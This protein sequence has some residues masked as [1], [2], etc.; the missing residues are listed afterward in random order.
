MH[1]V[2]DQRTLRWWRV[3]STLAAGNLLLW[4]AVAATV[5]TT[6]D[7]VRWH[8]ALSGTFTA[9]CAF[10]SFLPRIDLERYCLVDSPAS[11]MVA[12]RSAATIAEISF[13]IQNALLLHEIAGHADIP[14]IQS[15]AIPIV[16]ALTLAQVFCWSSVIT[17]S[18]LGHAIEESLWA[19]TFAVVGVCLAICVG[20]LSGMWR[21]IAVVGS[22]ACLVY[23][24]FMVTVDV[25]M[26][27]R[28]W[29][30]GLGEGEPRL[31]LRDG[32][33]DALHRRVV[34][35]EWKTWKPE[36]AWLTGYFTLAVWISVA[37]VCIPRG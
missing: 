22:V 34:T 32:W 9:V 10:R 31:G 37:M 5:D 19:G 36:V 35:R 18:H 8:L 6:P 25:P 14:W 16:A 12:G 3:L 23:V 7:Y 33:A 20:D 17:L 13:A 1:P 26:Y 30:Q 28:R 11:S 24:T 15:L 27:V 29:R 21:N 4:C 2:N